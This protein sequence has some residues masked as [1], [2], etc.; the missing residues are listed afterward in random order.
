MIAF[1]CIKI[2]ERKTM[3]KFL[4]SLFLLSAT[5][6]LAQDTFSIVAVDSTTGEIGSA[7]A[8][9]LGIIG[10]AVPHGAQIISDVIPGKGAIHTQAYYKPENQQTAHDQMIAGSAPQQILDYVT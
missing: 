4:T 8:S 6:S 10:T 7:G 5:Y 3:R 2:K 1:L 9:C